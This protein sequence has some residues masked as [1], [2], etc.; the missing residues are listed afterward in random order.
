MRFNPK[1]VTARTAAS[2]F[3]R[4]SEI[5]QTKKALGNIDLFLDESGALT[6]I[7]AGGFF[8]YERTGPCDS[9][10]SIEQTDDAR[11]GGRLEVRFK[12]RGDTLL[13]SSSPNWLGVADETN[14][15]T[16]VVRFHPEAREGG[17]LKTTFTTGIF[18]T[19]V[20]PKDY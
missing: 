11:L 19:T 14:N 8:R 10:L 5:E 2:E 18:E 1:L 15:V 16:A 7:E 9:L 6:R 12:A 3:K 17:R 13:V 4:N 20:D